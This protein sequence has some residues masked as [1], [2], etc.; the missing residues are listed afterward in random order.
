MYNC[1]VVVFRENEITLVLELKE[2]NSIL[3]RDLNQ[4]L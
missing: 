4:G 2:K 1:N 3:D